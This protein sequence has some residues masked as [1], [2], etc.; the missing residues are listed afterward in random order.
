MHSSAHID[1]QAL[2][3]ALNWRYAT[4]KFDT[5]R[6]IPDH[7]WHTLEQSLVL[8][9][10]SF[11]L[12]PWKFLVVQTT[13]TR[14]AL[15]PHAWGQTQ[16]VD[17]SHFVV[18]TALRDIDDA[19]INKFLQSI[20][21][22][23]QQPVEKTYPYRDMLIGYVKQTVGQHQPWNTRQVY[24]ALGTLLTTAANL[25]IDACPMEGI[26]P[27]EF[28]KVLKL[29]GTPYTTVVAAALGYRHADDKYAGYKKVRF[30]TSDVIEHV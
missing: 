19:Y 26:D 12:Q 10:S 28:D 6:K 17:A 20:A 21:D 25:G 14:Q 18:L 2:L 16:V 11:G 5:A 13:A 9:P 4:K 7:D 27:A 3:T 23:R 8:S 24:L 29:D 15:L 22:A 1:R 30:P